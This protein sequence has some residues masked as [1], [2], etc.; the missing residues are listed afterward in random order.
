MILFGSQLE[1]YWKKLLMNER[2]SLCCND[3]IAR[4]LLGQIDSVFASTGRLPQGLCRFEIDIETI[5]ATDWLSIQN[6]GMKI[7]YSQRQ[8]DLEVAAVGA[9]DIVGDDSGLSLPKALSDIESR[10][11]H[12]KGALR[13]YGGVC[14][15]A[16]NLSD[17][18]WTG[19]GSFCFVAPQFE[20][21][22]E[23]GKT[24]F[25][26]NAF[27]RPNDNNESI[28]Q[29]FS[30]AFENI[31]FDLS[32]T[33]AVSETLEVINCVNHPDKSQW[34]KAITRAVTDLADRNMDKIVLAR[35]SILKM[36]DSV[37]PV[38][39]LNKVRRLNTRTY[40]F[41]FQ[42]EDN[43]A[44]ICSSPECL[45]SRRG[46][47]I[48]SEA[49]AGSCLTGDSDE[50][51]LYHRDKLT[52]SEKEVEEH[53]YVFDNVKADL[54][55]I[56]SEINVIGDRQI[57]SLSYVQHFCSKFGGVLKDGIDTYDIIEALHPTA[58]VNGFPRETAKEEI[59]KCETFS[60][61]WYAGPVGWI[62]EDSSEFAVGIRSARI[63]DDEISLFAG[64][65]L[66]RASD[67][68]TEWEETENK[69]SLF[70]D[71]IES[72]AREQ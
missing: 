7:Y 18:C 1:V 49:I 23:N 51:R 5:V 12:G 19:F 20:L 30:N 4:R 21:R 3:T 50:E 39:L 41:C 40:D 9:A 48:T 24:T 42:L 25:A 72:N 31:S 56:C 43:D 35:K 63:K 6:A 70:L 68:E 60:R 69:L 58:A 53:G 55:K 65:G 46:K 36:S 52:R 66:V 37:D 45:F 61:G 28:S 32:K 13:Y 14:F 33:P 15:D 11:A 62:G 47:Q 22:C 57:V 27:C 67:P 59:R 44:F 10:I 29:N 71:V 54:A 16:E 34:Q 64:A 2:T 38:G 17:G 8:G 26:Y